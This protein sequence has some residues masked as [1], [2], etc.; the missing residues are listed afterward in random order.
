VVKSNSQDSGY[1][2]RKRYFW[3]A[4]G[5]EDRTQLA[6]APRPSRNPRLRRG[7]VRHGSGR[8]NVLPLRDPISFLVEM[9][10]SVGL[11]DHRHAPLA[12]GETAGPILLRI[13]ADLRAGRNTH[14]L[15]DDRP[16]TRAWRPISTPSSNKSK[17][18]TRAKLLIRT[19]NA[20]NRSL[21]LSAGNDRALAHRCYRALRRGELLGL[22]RRKTNF[23]GG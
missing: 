14:H 19:L 9:L 11:G 13:E 2:R 20:E 17:S 6:I 4:E 1:L 7:S 3:P 22:A 23:G 10:G 21:D 8:A 5:A 12:D 16:R 18:S 15:S